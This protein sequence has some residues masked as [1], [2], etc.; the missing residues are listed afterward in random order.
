MQLLFAQLSE[1]TC[2]LFNK[3]QNIINVKI[4]DLFLISI[5]QKMNCLLEI[6]ARALVYSK[7]RITTNI[8]LNLIEAIEITCFASRFFNVEGIFGQECLCKFYWGIWGVGGVN[9]KS[10]RR[11]SGEIKPYSSCPVLLEKRGASLVSLYE[12]QH[13]F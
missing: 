11:L 6:F 2:L 5:L 9:R 4:D 8:K 1:I 3:K 13:Q 10:H 12:N 7:R